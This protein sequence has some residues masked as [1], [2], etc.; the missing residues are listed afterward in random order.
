MMDFF[1]QLKTFDKSHAD[2]YRGSQEV[3]A[4]PTVSAS[5]VT[6]VL[7]K[8]PDGRTVLHIVN[9]ARKSGSAGQV[10][11]VSIVKSPGMTRTRL[12][13]VAQSTLAASILSIWEP[14][15]DTVDAT[16][17]S[18]RPDTVFTVAKSNAKFSGT[19]R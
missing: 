3:A 5:N 14:A 13:D 7:N 1:K 2:L 4:A 11:V 12:P 15:P 10:T 8:L 18:D 6:M 16:L 19:V 9:D 17:T